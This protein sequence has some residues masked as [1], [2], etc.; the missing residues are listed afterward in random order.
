MP[1]AV[2]VQEGD[3]VDYT[4]ATAVA[5]GDVVVQGSLVGV[6]KQPIAAN[7]AGALAVVG[8][9]DF[10]KATDLEIAVG[11]DVYWDEAEQQ[12]KTDS[13]A[14]ANPWLGKSVQ[15]AATISAALASASTTSRWTA[16][17]RGVPPLPGGPW[18][19]SLVSRAALST[20]PRVRLTRPSCVRAR[21]RCAPSRRR[22][23]ALG[24]ADPGAPIRG[25][26]D[27]WIGGWFPTAGAGH[28][29]TGFRDVLHRAQT[30]GG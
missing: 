21:V 20:R 24:P 13:E 4:P 9:F 17:P 6:A 23:A 15:A 16:R 11:S 28:A 25:R 3:A 1:T 22:A 19:R 18:T 8:V 30:S 5:A 29:P 27:W 2:F 10:P 14:G 26:A 12:A 7:Q